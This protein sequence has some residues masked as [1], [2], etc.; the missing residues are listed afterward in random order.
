MTRAADH[1][2]KYGLLKK[3]LGL[4]AIFLLHLPYCLQVSW[5]FRQRLRVL[6]DVPADQRNYWHFVPFSS[7]SR[8]N[9]TTREPSILP[10]LPVDP[11][12]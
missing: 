3:G 5:Y 8:T 7:L 11:S 6:E 1:V 4:Y 12:A 9:A 2:W 10:E